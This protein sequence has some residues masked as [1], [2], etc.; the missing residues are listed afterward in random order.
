MLFELSYKLCND[1]S[2]FEKILNNFN[3]L[4]FQTQIKKFIQSESDTNN[5]KI[6]NITKPK[7]NDTTEPVTKTETPETNITNT[8]Y[9]LWEEKEPVNITIKFNHTWIE[10]TKL[11]P[12]WN[13]K[14][15]EVEKLIN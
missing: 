14:K 11:I 2:V 15:Q 13:E 4:P 8:D 12:K 9:D 6:D 5:N 7:N 1:K 10:E 3:D